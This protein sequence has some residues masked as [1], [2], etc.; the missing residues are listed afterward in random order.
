MK[1]DTGAFNGSDADEPSRTI[2]L[3]RWEFPHYARVLR[4]SVTTPEQAIARIEQLFSEFDLQDAD[5]VAYFLE[6][7]NGDSLH[8]YVTRRRWCL[9]SKP[10]RGT[11]QVTFGDPDATG[12]LVILVPEWTPTKRTYF[13]PRRLA[14]RCI[15]QWMKDGTLSDCVQWVR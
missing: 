4:E 11:A 3:E 14:V 5:G 13:I 10:T 12:Y 6:A 7:N 9:F 15:K 8:V 2:E 1:S